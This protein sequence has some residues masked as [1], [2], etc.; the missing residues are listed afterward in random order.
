[1]KSTIRD[2][3]KLAAKIDSDDK[4]SIETTLKEALEWLDENQNAEKVNYDE[5]MA[6]LEAVFNPIIRRVYE[7]ALLIQKMNP[8]MSCEL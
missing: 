7:E 3:D 2:D 5:K 8:M 6:E 1:M 4:E